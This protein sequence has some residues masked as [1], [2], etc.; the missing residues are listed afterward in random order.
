[1]ASFTVFAVASCDICALS[2]NIL[3]NCFC[4]NSEEIRDDNNW[5]ATDAAAAAAAAVTD[6]SCSLL[7]D[8]DDW[9]IISTNHLALR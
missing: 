3:R 8:A 1:M 2:H 4:R 5:M 6:A 9:K 7:S